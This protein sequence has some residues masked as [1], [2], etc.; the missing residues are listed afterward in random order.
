M[1]YDL[2]L[3]ERIVLALRRIAQAIDLYSRMLLQRHGL[4]APQIAVLRE[5]LQHGQMTPGELSEALHLSQPTMAG[6][7]GR[8]EH[9]QLLC[10]ERDPH[11]R[12]SFLIRLTPAGVTAAEKA[13][14]LLRDRFRSELAR[15]PQSQQT[16]MLATLQRVG[17][18]LQAPA[19]DETPF[20]F[21]GGQNGQ[22]SEKP[23]EP[24]RRRKK[25]T[26]H[27]VTPRRP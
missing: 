25:R 15:L 23:S 12:R 1:P 19:M 24:A 21:T 14:P 3:D 11:D 2:G 10:R 13:P 20:L 26:R 5:L 4:T 6:V 27:K 8:L 22:N 18:M 9:K 16:D 7:L 17:E